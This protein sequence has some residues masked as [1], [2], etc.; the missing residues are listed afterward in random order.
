[1]SRTYRSP[2][3]KLYTLTRSVQEPMEIED[4]PI[5]HHISIDKINLGEICMQKYDFDKNVFF[6]DIYYNEYYKSNI[7]LRQ[8]LYVCENP[9]DYYY[10]TR[11]LGLD[12]LSEFENRPERDII[13]INPKSYNENEHKNVIYTTLLTKMQNPIDTIICSKSTKTIYVLDP[14]DENVRILPMDFMTMSDDYVYTAQMN[15]TLD[16]TFRVLF[17]RLIKNESIRITTNTYKF[18]AAAISHMQLFYNIVVHT[19]I[20]KHSDYSLTTT[21]GTT[22]YD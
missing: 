5:T 7:N 20:E 18:L 14:K 15:T 21:N 6:T 11:Y 13:L 3:G 19:A 9:I 1:M 22:L 12:T 17:G 2:D 16:D 4:E 8:A 10:F